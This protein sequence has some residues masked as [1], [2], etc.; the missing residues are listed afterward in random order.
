M[1]KLRPIVR[2]A[3]ALLALTLMVNPLILRA[4]GEA[5]GKLSKAKEQYDANKDGQLNDEEKAAAK[6]GATAKAKETRETNLAKYDANQD[7][8][9]DADERARKKADEQ[10][11]R[12][13]EREA[14]KAE[15]QAKKTAK[16]AAK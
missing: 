14:K 8:K 15:R 4:E 1:C 6:A 5:K 13:A 10:S 16:E 2:V 7:G 12:D 11:A 3:P 9:L